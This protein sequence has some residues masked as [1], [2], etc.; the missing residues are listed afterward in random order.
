MP[1]LLILQQVEQGGGRASKSKQV[2]KDLTV[3]SM[4]LLC[5]VLETNTY[6]YA[7]WIFSSISDTSPQHL[8]DLL[9]PF[10]L[11]YRDLHLTF[12]PL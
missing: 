10:I 12:V 7:S 9:Q 11:T 4:I 1:D 3:I 5:T 2:K 6:Y 8:S